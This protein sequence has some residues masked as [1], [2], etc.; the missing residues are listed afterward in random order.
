MGVPH[1]VSIIKLLEF[2][3]NRKKKLFGNCFA[4]LTGRAKKSSRV[5]SFFEATNIVGLLGPDAA[6]GHIKKEFIKYFY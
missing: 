2:A 6:R 3:Q 5:E 4:Q 1:C